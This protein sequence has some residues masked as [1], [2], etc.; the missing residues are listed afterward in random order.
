VLEGSPFTWTVPEPSDGGANPDGHDT[1]P[2]IPGGNSETNNDG[3]LFCSD[4]TF[5]ADGRVLAA[6]GT[7]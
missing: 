2:L 4:H 1:H 7:A 5:L 3:A 6:G